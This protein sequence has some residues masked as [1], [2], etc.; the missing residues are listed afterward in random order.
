LGVLCDVRAAERICA[1]VKIAASS[2]R[3][4]EAIA[5]RQALSRKQTKNAAIFATGSPSTRNIAQKHLGRQTKRKK[6]MLQDRLSMT[7]SNNFSNNHE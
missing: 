6:Q 3:A 4:R 1:H 2:H 5:R 7:Y